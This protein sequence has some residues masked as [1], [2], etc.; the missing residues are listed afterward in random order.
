MKH[1]ESFDMGQCSEDLSKIHV[2][3]R[4]FPVCEFLFDQRHE[5]SISPFSKWVDVSVR[6]KF[7]HFTRLASRHFSW[8]QSQAIPMLYKGDV[9]G[10]QGQVK[11]AFLSILIDSSINIKLTFHPSVF[12]EATIR[13]IKRKCYRMA[14]RCRRLRIPLSTW[15]TGPCNAVVGPKRSEKKDLRG[16]W[17]LW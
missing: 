3:P 16:V 1:S 7:L 14:P 6:H 8:E 13:H 15:P 17:I 10:D 12:E 4:W 5:M 9:S 11:L 2:S